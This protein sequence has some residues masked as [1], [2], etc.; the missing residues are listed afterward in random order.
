MI[1]FR[2]Y[3]KR[4]RLQVGVVR[5][6]YFFIIFLCMYVCLFCVYAY[7]NMVI[8]LRYY[9]IFFVIFFIDSSIIIVVATDFESDVFFI[10]VCVYIFMIFNNFIILATLFMQNSYF[11]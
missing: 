1:F 2:A 5:I 3:F 7:F 10:F 9:Y 4:N 11:I 6:D 8:F